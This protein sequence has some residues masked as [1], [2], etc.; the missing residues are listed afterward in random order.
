MFFDKFVIA[1]TT[2][3]PVFPGVSWIS[4]VTPLACVAHVHYLSLKSGRPVLRGKDASAAHPDCRRR[5]DFGAHLDD[6]PC[7]RTVAEWLRSHI[8]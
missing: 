7:R 3:S 1:R 2:F 8:R 5:R 6:Y 4:L